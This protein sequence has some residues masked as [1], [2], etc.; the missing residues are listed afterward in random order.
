MAWNP[1]NGTTVAY[2]YDVA[3][4][5][6]G[7]TNVTANG[8]PIS[9]YALTLDGLGNHRQATHTQPLFPILPNQTNTYAYDSDNRL[10]QLDGDTVTFNPS[11]FSRR[12]R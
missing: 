4:R 7:L 6:V 8:S 2:G 11:G 1:A 10:T 12:E 3:G 5:L 9:S